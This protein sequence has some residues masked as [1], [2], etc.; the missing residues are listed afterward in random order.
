MIQALHTD[1][2]Q[3]PRFKAGELVHHKRYG[4]RGV[5]VDA[6]LT[7]LASEEWYQANQT[8]P[9]R[10]Q[11]WYRV[12]VDHSTQTTYVAQENLEP[13]AEGHP[14]EHPLVAF[15]FHDFQGGMHIRNE[16]PWSS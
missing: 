10:E 15:F 5:V 3:E 7:C 6:D 4:Y 13:D 16:V 1:A 2:R 14:V 11:P 12:L 8:Q 9:A